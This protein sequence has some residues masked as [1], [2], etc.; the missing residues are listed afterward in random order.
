M[1]RAAFY[2]YGLHACAT[3]RRRARE[4]FEAFCY[5]A[6]GMIAAAVAFLFFI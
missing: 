6:V 5:G 4:R 3:R 2:P 1:R